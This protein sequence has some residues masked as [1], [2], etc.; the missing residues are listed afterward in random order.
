MIGLALGP[1]HDLIIENGQF[2]RINDNALA[3]QQIKSRLLFFRGEWF[4]DVLAGIPYFQRIFTK[5]VDL[6]EIESIFKQS[7][8]EYPLVESLNE[9]SLD[10]VGG[11]SRRLT[12][13]AAVRTIYGGED[14]AEVTI[15]A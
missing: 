1:N 10:Y 3:I 5:P 2:K 4:L 8:L 14:F 9:F 7:I 15:N 13:L 11:D 6:G 12:V